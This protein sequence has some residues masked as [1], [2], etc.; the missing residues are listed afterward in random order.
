SYGIHFICSPTDCS[1]DFKL[2]GTWINSTT[3]STQ[4]N[5]SL[6]AA[7]PLGSYGYR[8][9]DASGQF[10]NLANVVVAPPLPAPTITFVTP[11]PRTGAA[12]QPGVGAT[13]R[14]TI[15][16]DIPTTCTR[17]FTTSRDT[18]HDF[19]IWYDLTFG[20]SYTYDIVCTNDAGVANAPVSVKY[21][22]L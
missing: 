16:T 21:Q 11:N 7:T 12:T 9:M 6:D 17:P 13:V 1:N 20:N 2:D 19:D 22:V 10:S 5:Y 8:A 3:F 18:K 4:N 15:T 14:T